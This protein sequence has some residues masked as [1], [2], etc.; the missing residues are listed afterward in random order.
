MRAFLPRDRGLDQMAL[1]GGVFL[2]LR[3]FGQSGSGCTLSPLLYL[4][5]KYLLDSHLCVVLYV[6]TQFGFYSARS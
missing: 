2:M 5:Q 6:I 1:E 4:Y 3:L